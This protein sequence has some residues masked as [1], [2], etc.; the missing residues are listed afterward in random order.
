MEGAE[1]VRILKADPYINRI[2]GGIYSQNTFPPKL[3]RKRVFVGN[4]DDSDQSGSHWFVVSTMRKNK[5]D[6]LC[7]Y[8]SSPAELPDLYR[9]MKRDPKMRI[10]QFS[11]RLQGPESTSCGAW[12]CFVI[13]AESR[14]FRSP[15]AI[16][17]Y[18]FP[19]DS[20]VYKADLTVSTAIS[21]LLPVKRSLENLVYDVN[22]IKSQ[23]KEEKEQK[24]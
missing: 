10:C 21:Y 4:A 19:P 14:G 24:E 3:P 2:F 5:I 23:E 22:F 17:K 18:F 11:R 12:V 13:W 1:I 9:I 16:E 15:R 20:D 8:K 7:S 6:Y